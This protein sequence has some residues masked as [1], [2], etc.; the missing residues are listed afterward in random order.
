VQQEEEEEEE[1]GEGEEEEDGRMN[2]DFSTTWKVSSSST[3]KPWEL[4][5]PR[6]AGWRT[7]PAC[8]F[9]EFKMPC[10]RER[11]IIY[12]ETHLKLLRKTTRMI[13]KPNFQEMVY[14]QSMA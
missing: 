3:G 4:L 7:A 14:S 9:C 10:S 11:A 2:K 12:V 6:L 1:E 8:Q 13:H 5:P